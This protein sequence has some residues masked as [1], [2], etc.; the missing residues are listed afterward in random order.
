[1]KQ[2]VNYIDDFNM[3]T[4][5]DKDGGDS[6]AYGFAILYSVAVLN[7]HSSYAY[8]DSEIPEITK[9]AY[10][11]SVLEKQSGRYIRHPDSSMW[12]SK[13][14]T[15]SRD[16]LTPLL[17]YLGVKG[18]WAQVLR[19]FFAHSLRFFL[20]A[21][22]TRKNAALPNTPG[23][24]WKLPDL[25]GP[26]IWATWIRILRLYPL[27]P[28]LFLFDTPT[29]IGAVIYRF[30]STSTLQ[31]NHALLTDFSTRIMPTFTSLLA[32]RIYGKNT[33]IK[34]LILTFNVP[35]FN[36]PVDKYLIPMVE[37]WGIKE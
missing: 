19:L 29:L 26:D 31:M 34:A 35:Y 13:I 18:S 1:M 6:C 9:T 24:S 27:Y 11:K 16:Q 14:Y 8:L 25:T 28:L 21:W 22:N 5:S 23:Y 32:R 37:S 12:Y 20:F 15:L 36:P 2:L 10:A 7:K 4:T 17:V 33:P 30:F 3:I